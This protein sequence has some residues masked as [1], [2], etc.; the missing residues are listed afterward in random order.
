MHVTVIGLLRENRITLQH[1]NVCAYA[2]SPLARRTNGK[3]WSLPHDWRLNVDLI[4][5]WSLAC[6]E[7]WHYRVMLALA[8]AL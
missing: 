2:Q 8:T 5:F 7:G 1:W 6:V 4:G 3:L